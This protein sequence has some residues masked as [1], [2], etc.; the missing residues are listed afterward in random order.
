VNVVGLFNGPVRE[1]KEMLY[2]FEEPFVVDH[3][4]FEVAFGNY[5]APL[6]LAIDTTLACIER[7]RNKGGDR[8]DPNLGD[9]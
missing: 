8:P 9:P 3:S 6:S 1:L 5:A 7:T 2:E 4:Q